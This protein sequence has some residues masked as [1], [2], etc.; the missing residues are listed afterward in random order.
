[1]LSVGGAF[2][3]LMAEWHLPPDYII[4][5]WTDELLNL[6]VEKLTDRKLGVKVKEPSKP[7]ASSDGSALARMG[8]MVKVIDNR[9]D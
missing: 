1:M 5:N 2:E 6:M 7:M 3:F 4:N 9:G 8:N